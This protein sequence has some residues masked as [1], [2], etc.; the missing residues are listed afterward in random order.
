MTT[1]STIIS[2]SLRLINVLG[3]GRRT[4]TANE[5]A[6]GIEALNSMMD[7]FSIDGLM[8][9]QTL[10]ENFPLVVGTAN[11]TI[12]SGG[13]FNTTRPVKITNAFLRDSS[14]NDYPLDIIDNLAY[15][16]IPLKTVTSRPRYLYYDAIYPLAYVRLMYVPSFADTIYINSWKQLQQFTDGTTT[17]S[18]PPGYERMIAYNLAI[19]LHPEYQGSQLSPETISIAKDSKAIIKRLN[20]KIPIAD[21]SGPMMVRGGIGKR[22]IYTG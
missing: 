18:L 8:I 2:R 11:Y 10:E 21:V 1:A 20:A 15:D 4:L 22:N 19:E 12:G 14:N 16:S 13:T 7:S 17:I 6:D 3:T 9:Y 5:L